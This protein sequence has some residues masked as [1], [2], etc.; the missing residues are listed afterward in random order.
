MIRN[1]NRT[2]DVSLK[3]IRGWTA[4]EYAMATV[5]SPGSGA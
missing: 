1:G 4:L 3:D 2:T 5:I